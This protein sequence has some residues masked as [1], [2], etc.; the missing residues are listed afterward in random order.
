MLHA[1]SVI[2]HANICGDGTHNTLTEYLQYH[3]SCMEVAGYLASLG[4]FSA[5]AI[6][7]AE[8]QADIRSSFRPCVY[9][10]HQQCSERPFPSA[11][12]GFQAHYTSGE[13]PAERLNV[14]SSPQAE[15]ELY[16]TMVDR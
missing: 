14:E 7:R 5:D 13:P 3:S 2:T 12:A 11:P 9:I 1:A 16:C 4:S 6:R 10:K 15:I 8:A